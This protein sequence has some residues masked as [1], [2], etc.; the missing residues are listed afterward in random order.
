MEIG[1]TKESMRYQ[2]QLPLH[3]KAWYC[4]SYCTKHYKNACCY[5]KQKG[6][7]YLMIGH[8]RMDHILS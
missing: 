5:S 3:E 7:N 6:R 1:A 8:P 4:I 2:F